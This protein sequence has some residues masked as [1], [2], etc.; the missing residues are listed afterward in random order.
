MDDPF[1]FVIIGA[2]P[3]DTIH[4]LPTTARVMGGL[5]AQ[6]VRTLDTAS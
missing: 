6:A 1:D 2:G 3:A 4:A 5:F